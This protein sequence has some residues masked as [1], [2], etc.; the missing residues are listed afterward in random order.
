MFDVASHRKSRRM[1]AF[2]NHERQCVRSDEAGTGGCR[3]GAFQVVPHGAP[4]FPGV[5][6]PLLDQRRG[7]R[8]VRSRSGQNPGSGGKAGVDLF[9]QLD[10]TDADDTPAPDS[11]TRCPAVP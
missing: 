2:V 3:R 4:C 11:S 8:L 9:N 10:R 5:D 6:E 7:S 1:G